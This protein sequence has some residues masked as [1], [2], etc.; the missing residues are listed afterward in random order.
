[1][2]LVERI[3]VCPMTFKSYGPICLEFKWDI[4]DSSIWDWMA[5]NYPGDSG[6]RLD[7]MTDRM[8]RYQPM[9]AY[10][11]TKIDAMRFKLLFQDTY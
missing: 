9:S 5:E 8:I 11:D 1:M 2:R 7:F 3:Y 4:F 10:F 6:P